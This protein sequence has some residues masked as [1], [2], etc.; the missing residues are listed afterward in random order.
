MG[1]GEC[2][3]DWVGLDGRHAQVSGP[4]PISRHPVGRRWI[5]C[6]GLAPYTLLA[7]PG[8]RGQRDLRG[9][10]RLPAHLL[11][12]LV[13]CGGGCGP[14]PAMLRSHSWLCAWYHSWWAQETLQDTGDQSQGSHMQKQRSA[15]Y[16]LLAHGVSL[17]WALFTLSLILLLQFWVFSLLVNK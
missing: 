4:S 13:G 6:P 15:P 1:V 3:P 7:G 10:D 8:G 17:L 5:L 12:F 2:K 14:Q 16:H 9:L 11:C